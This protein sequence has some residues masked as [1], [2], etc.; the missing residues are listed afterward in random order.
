MRWHKVCGIVCM[1]FGVAEMAAGFLYLGAIAYYNTISGPIEF[2]NG[3]YEAL[4]KI[5]L[6]WRNVLSGCFILLAGIAASGAAISWLKQRNCLGT[7][8]ALSFILLGA[9]IAFMTR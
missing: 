2:S 3:A 8:F 1:L 7:F 9:A 4:D 6:T 5:A